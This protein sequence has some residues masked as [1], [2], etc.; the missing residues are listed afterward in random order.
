MSK[1]KVDCGDEFV[2]GKTHFF[3]VIVEDTITNN[4]LELPNKFV[5]K[6][7]GDLS[8]PVSIKVPGGM[9]WEIDM[10]SR[11]EKCKRSRNGGGGVVTNKKSMW[12]CNEE[13]K[14]FARHYSLKHG[15]FMVF[16]YEGGSNFS[17]AIFHYIGGA[18]IRYP[19]T[20]VK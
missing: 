5:K 19:T 1:K 6:H 4:K 2:P 11:M 12:L 8:S 15:H 16:Q 13:W 18:E 10:M 9:T 14:R 3:K 17:V 20:I 7:G